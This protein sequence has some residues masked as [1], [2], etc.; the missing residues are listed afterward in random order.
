MD[1]GLFVFYT[2]FP[3]PLGI[4]FSLAVLR[5]RRHEGDGERGD[6]PVGFTKKK[7]VHKGLCLVAFLF[8]GGWV[9]IAPRLLRADE[10]GVQR[11]RR[12]CPEGRGSGCL[13][14]YGK[15]RMPLAGGQ[16]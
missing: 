15:G 14:T 4:P 6:N 8:Y 16:P 3:C 2:H 10:V 11:G 13:K 5:L 12:G 9:R 1:R 7:W